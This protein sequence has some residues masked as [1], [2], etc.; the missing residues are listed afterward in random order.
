LGDIV[1]NVPRGNRRGRQPLNW[2]H[3][4]S[5]LI[6]DAG[7]EVA[8]VSEQTV[9]KMQRDWNKRHPGHRLAVEKHDGV[10]MVVRR[11]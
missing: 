2:D 8:G 11:A 10:L 3:R 4:F 6:V 9:R 5:E 1:F 7:C